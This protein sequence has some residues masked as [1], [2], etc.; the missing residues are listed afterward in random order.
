MVKRQRRE[1]QFDPISACRDAEFH[2]IE[3]VLHDGTPSSEV[4][5]SAQLLKEFDMVLDGVSLRV[6]DIPFRDPVSFKAGEL[7]K[8]FDS[9]E[10]IL[11]GH[12]QGKKILQWIKEGVN[13]SEFMKPFKGTFQAVKYDC[14]SRPARIFGNHGS[15]KE[16]AD[17]ISGTLEG[18]LL[19]GAV[20]LWGKV[21]EVAPPPPPLSK[22]RLCVDARS[23]LNL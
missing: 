18:R 8:H 6:A 22:P 3:W 4:T 14:D 2:F 10:M 5:E 19:T 1:Q 12:G 11:N 20:R 16:F 17:F 23:C 9:W 15:C 7:H 13:V 21:G